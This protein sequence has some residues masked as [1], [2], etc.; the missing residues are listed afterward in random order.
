MSD[1]G[2]KLHKVLADHGLGSRREMERWITAGRVKVDGEP[3]QIGQR[4]QAEAIIE[5]DGKAL[6]RRQHAEATRVL[7][8]NK[9]VGRICSR[10]DP[11]G[12]PTVFDDLPRLH[13]G[14]WVAVGRLDVQTSGLLLLTN[15]GR[16]ANK[17]MHPS[18][19][20]DR[21]YAVRV[22]GL[23]SEEEIDTLKSGVLIDEVLCRF[24]DLQHYDGRGRNHW[25]HAV[26][27]EGRNHEVRNLF[28]AVDRAVSRLKRVR[29]GPVALPSHVREGRTAEMPAEDVKSL[30]AL[31]GVPYASPPKQGRKPADGAKKRP[32]ML[33]P[34]PKVRPQ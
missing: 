11:E 10:R 21:E 4:V 1:S 31:V 8:M 12:R 34:Y 6:R 18:T 17:L 2:E 24:S 22:D 33:L 30:C 27:L 9:A 19:G 5:V 14:R 13:S 23:L 3:A 26:L 29:Y 16:L 15:D 32:S 20:L 28:A 25:Y 7:V